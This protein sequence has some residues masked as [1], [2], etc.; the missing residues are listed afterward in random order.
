[1]TGF[2]SI[3]IRSIAAGGGGIGWVDEGGLLHIV[4][5]APAQFPGTS[6][7][8]IESASRMQ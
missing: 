5:T 4:R 1:M 8:R 3:D 6:G 7:A 2:P